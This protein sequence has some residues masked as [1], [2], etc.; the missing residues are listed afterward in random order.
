MIVVRPANEAPVRV[1]GPLAAEIGMLT[2][3]TVTLFGTI[4][5]TTP[6]RTIEPTRYEVLAIDGQKPHVGML[7]V[8]QGEVWLESISPVRLE[9][10]PDALRAQIGAKVYVLGAVRNGVLKVQSFGVIRRPD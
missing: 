4:Q 10:A 6:W 3:A 2:G 5:A 1:G 9:G 7:R 8:E